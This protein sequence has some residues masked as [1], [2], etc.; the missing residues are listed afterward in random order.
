MVCLCSPSCVLSLDNPVYHSSQRCDYSLL[1]DSFAIVGCEA[2]CL[3]CKQ[4]CELIS[5][6]AG[7]PASPDF[8]LLHMPHI[9]RHAT[10]AAANPE[11]LQYCG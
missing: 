11:V 2:Q 7:K 3:T 4:L 9:S 1:A 5:A 10:K 8:S 6:L